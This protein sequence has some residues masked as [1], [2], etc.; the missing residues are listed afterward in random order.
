MN[1]KMQCTAENKRKVLSL[2]KLNLS[3]LTTV[4]YSGIANVILDNRGKVVPLQSNW[5]S[6]RVVT[7]VETA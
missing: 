2:C 1:I 4:V 3:K 5:Q 6:F 7:T